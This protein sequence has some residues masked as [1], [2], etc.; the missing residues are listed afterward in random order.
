MST[1]L[2]SSTSTSARM[3]IVLGDFR[4]DP[5]L[6][7]ISHALASLNNA[8]LLAG[9]AREDDRGWSAES[10]QMYAAMASNGHGSV[11]NSKF[12]RRTPGPD[13]LRLSKQSPITME[14]AF[15]SGLLGAGALFRYFLIH[16]EALGGWVWRVRQ[17]WAIERAT[18]ER[19][20]GQELAGSPDLLDRALDS[21]AHETSLELIALG[22]IDVQSDGF[23]DREPDEVARNR[24]VADSP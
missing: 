11:L 5:S 4:L 1:E 23:G 2:A 17:G 16:P 12:T 8:W 6:G 7:S 22:Q 15:G 24:T 21:D 10:L 9:L 18:F 14:L 3:T 13:V 19:I 20:N